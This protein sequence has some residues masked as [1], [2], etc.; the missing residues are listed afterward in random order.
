[1][2]SRDAFCSR[3][4]KKNSSIATAAFPLRPTNT[5]ARRIVLETR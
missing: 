2:E 4:D 5:T 3:R 1:M